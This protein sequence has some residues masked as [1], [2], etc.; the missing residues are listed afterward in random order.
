[1]GTGW[2]AQRVHLPYISASS[3][4]DLAAIVD[5]D[6]ARLRSAAVAADVATA[7]RIGGLRDDLDADLAVVCT[8]P[9]GHASAIAECLARGWHVICEKPFV[10]NS[11]DARTLISTAARR[12]LALRCCQTSRFRADVLAVAEEVSS[13]RLGKVRHIRLTWRRANGVPASGGGRSVGALWDLGA[14]LV[15]LIWALSDLGDPTDI[16]ASGMRLSPQQALR[17]TATWQGE[18]G[19]GAGDPC[20]AGAAVHLG[21]CTRDRQCG[22]TLGHRGSS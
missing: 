22:G 5:P 2:V 15:D 20:L 21:F 8:P 11:H 13:G 7:P 19:E 1:M 9:D 3:S 14:H 18:P 12:G 16:A 17:L 6:P 10:T 4:I